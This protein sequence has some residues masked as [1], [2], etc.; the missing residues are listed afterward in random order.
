[1]SIFNVW[2]IAC[3]A[4]DVNPTGWIDTGV[5]LVERAGPATVGEFR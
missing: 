2:L 3:P 4:S 5:L 1:M